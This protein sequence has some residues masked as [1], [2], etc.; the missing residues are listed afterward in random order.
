[1]NWARAVIKVSIPAREITAPSHRDIMKSESHTT[2]D[3]ARNV[4]ILLNQSGFKSMFAGGCVRDR[5]LGITPKDY[6]IA[7]TASPEE[8][9]RLSRGAGLKA[10]PTGIDH[11]TVTIVTGTG[12]V[13]VT[14]LR[15][16]VATDGRHAVVSFDG[17]TFE[18][19]AARRD[20]TMNALFEDQNGKIFD[21]ANGRQDIQARVLRFVGAPEE[22]IREDYLRSIRYF[23]FWARFG[24]APDPAALAAIGNQRE[25][26][27]RLSRERVSSELWQI[28]TADHCA[29]ALIAMERAGVLAILWPEF[30]PI[31]HKVSIGLRNSRSLA[32]D[33]K[34]FAT[35]TLLLNLTDPGCWDD[36]RVSLFARG[37]RWSDRDLTA[38]I[39]IH[40]G[41]QNLKTSFPT[42]A[43]A[44]IFAGHL[45]S[46]PSRRSLA[47]FYGPIWHFLA[48]QYGDHVRQSNLAW[49]MANDTAFSFR[50][51][52]AMPLSGRDV[53]EY[54]P[55]LQGRDI[56]FVLLQV[57]HGFLNGLWQSRTEGLE[58]LRNITQTSE[59]SEEWEEQE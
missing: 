43:D 54:F 35:L 52:A 38:L 13:E 9:V 58:F 31:D 29:E 44:L 41:W 25:G 39:E 28:L 14:T 19:D 48:T 23:R 56:G 3:D 20:F 12:P 22:R 50:R 33:V 2:Y 51:Q 42:V 5:I 1:M 34:A 8:V 24:F 6:D 55:E 16:D 10:V 49:L 15:N 53:Q 21:Y 40:R 27:T 59:T 11:G 17:A 26:L 57:R 18:T 36:E 4:L 37:Q 32:P 46:E 7:T 45:E 30:I 47:G